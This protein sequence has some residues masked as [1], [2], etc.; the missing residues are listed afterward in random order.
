MDETPNFQLPF[1]AAS[2]AQKHVT[3]NE[4]LSRI[5]G[6]VHLRLLSLTLTLPPVD[7]SEGDSY[8][9][10]AGAVNAWAGYDSKVAVFCNGG[11]TFFSPQI[12]WQAWL[13]TSFERLTFT[14]L[15][16]QPGVVATSPN[17]AL[18]QMSI[19]EFDHVLTAGT[20]S[21]TVIDIP[22][23]GLVFGVSGVVTTAFTGSLSDWSLGV[24]GSVAQFGSGLGLAQGAYVLGMLGQPTTYYSN[25]PLICTANGG[26]FAAGTVRLCLHI[27]QLTYPQV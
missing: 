14:S 21:G 1:V 8:A 10:P 12:G 15:G 2:Q 26:D 24:S 20:T 27:L 11:W 25:T 4:G 13:M 17:G 9:V 5:D 3:V 23:N 6:V 22:A 18:T 7:A 16:W 19:L